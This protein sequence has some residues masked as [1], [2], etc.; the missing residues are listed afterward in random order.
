MRERERVCK[1]GWQPISTA[2]FNAAGTLYAY[3][4]SY[5]WSKGAEHHN[6]S[7]PSTIFLHAVKDE[8]IRQRKA[9]SG[10]RKS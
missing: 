3:A 8:E 10:G 1:S 2:T 4:V 6:P 9:K 5:E 7:N